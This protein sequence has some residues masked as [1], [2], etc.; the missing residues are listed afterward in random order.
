MMTIMD[1]RLLLAVAWSERGFR[2]VVDDNDYYKLRS[3]VGSTIAWVVSIRSVVL[4]HCHMKTS[5]AGRIFSRLN[6]IESRP[7]FCCSSRHVI[8]IF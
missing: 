2:S 6:R 8:I 3:F 4:C 1:F 7:H 5:R